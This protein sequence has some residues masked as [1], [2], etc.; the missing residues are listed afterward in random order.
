MKGYTKRNAAR[1]EAAKA[2]QIAAGKN[3]IGI[4][5]HGVPMDQHEYLAKVA[6]RKGKKQN[7]V[8]LELVSQYI[9]LDKKD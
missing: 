2:A 5:I 7:D 6:K 9:F 1:R 8:Y 3:T 4:T